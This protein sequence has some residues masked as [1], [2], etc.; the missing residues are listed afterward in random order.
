MES[1]NTKIHAIGDK[2]ELEANYAL[3]Q[4]AGKSA[5]FGGWSVDLKKNIVT[6]SDTICEIHD[7]P[8]GCQPKLE[9]AISFY[10]PQWKEKITQIFNDCAQKGI[11]Y[12]EEMEIISAKGKRKWVRTIGEAIRNEKGEITV[13]HGSFQDITQRKQSELAL[14]ESKKKNEELSTLMRLMADNMP[15]MLWAKNLDKEYIF[16][17]KAICDNLLGAESTEE[18]LGKTDMF[19]AL[20]QQ[21]KHPENPEWHTFGEVCRDS[22]D[23]TLQEMKALQFE[24]SGNVMGKFLTLDVHKAPLFDKQ[25]KLIGVVG[26][27]RDITEQRKTQE[28]IKT[29]R[30][31]YQTIINS[32]TEA[33]YVI[34]DSN[35]FI[36]VNLGAQKMYGYSREELVGKSPALIAADGMNDLKAVEK[37]HQEVAQTGISQSFEFWATKK[38]GEIFPKEVIIN[39][40]S[41]YGKDCLI[42]TARDIT[43]RK[44]TETANKAQY[45]I[46]LSI[47]TAKNIEELLE[48]IRTELGKLIDTSNFMVA[49]YDPERDTLKKLIYRDEKEDFTEW[50]AGK[51]LS[52]QVIKSGKSIFMKRKEIETFAVKNHL[53][54]IGTPAASWIGVPL[55]IKNKVAGAMVVQSYDN[56]EAFSKSDV[57]LIELIAH[58]TGI[59]LERQMML[60]DLL[61]S[62]EKAEEGNRL[63]TAFIN[64][65]S[66]EI[67]TP[68]NGILGFGGL[69][70]DKDLP[71]REKQKHYKILE[72]SSTRL[73]QTITDI[74]DISEITAGSVK[75]HKKG[76]NIMKTM[77]SLLKHANAA[78]SHKNILVALDVPGQHQELVLQTDEELLTKI[79]KALLSNAEKFTDKGRIILG[80]D[81]QDDWVRF[82]VKDTGRGISSD[83][84][85]Q[86]FEPFIQ[87]DVSVTRGH[88]GSG[89]GLSIA[90]GLVEVLGGR[91]W[92]ESEKGE[93]SA[94]FFTLPYLPAEAQ[95]KTRVTDTAHTERSGSNLILIAEDEETN[96][97]LLKT[98]VEKA[99]FSTLH[100]IHGAEAIELC[101]QYPEISLILMDIKMPVMNGLEATKQIKAFRPRLPVIALTAH[102]QTG[103]RQR[104]INAGCDEYLAKPV[105]LQELNDMIRE[106]VL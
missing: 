40:G 23:I 2:K 39:K 103:D 100:A 87:E 83:K 73:M 82:F 62:K 36:D 18:P 104:M 50:P 9:D 41:Y 91:L 72:H 57:S 34:D 96:Y 79:M 29:T 38:N 28:E 77:E 88:E 26:S 105:K 85:Q 20:R 94:F 59:Y 60:N 66:H 69:I 3:L 15:D 48:I 49:L 71:E 4:I 47:H 95:T 42:A 102:A 33:I 64:N 106:M 99:G 7:M 5:S 25:G 86:I 22:D 6:W 10:A 92:A 30:D 75:Q 24:E 51:S 19:F 16:A 55:I 43:E 90:R 1:K 35:T 74:L 61:A 78:C 13:V 21:A 63:K 56:S 54:L 84:L 76:I 32:I 37:I 52:G 8:Y 27:A 53:D 31:T 68:L 101:R 14:L 44:R 93:G 98:I 17:N 70:M 45:N 65:I 89:L 67:R 97:M 58:E 80:F 81:I 11:A 12:D 46:A